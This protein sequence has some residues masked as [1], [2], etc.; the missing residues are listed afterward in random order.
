[1]RDPESRIDWT[2]DLRSRLSTLRLSPAREEEIVEELSQHLD[3]RYQSFARAAE[4]QAR[5]RSR[6]S[7]AH[8]L[9]HHATPSSPTLPRPSQGGPHTGFWRDIGHDLRYAVRMPGSSLAGVAAHHAGVGT[10]Q[11]QSSLVNATQAQRCRSL[12]ANASSTSTEAALP[13]FRIAVYPRR[14]S[15]LDGAAA[16]PTSRQPERQHHRLSTAPSSPAIS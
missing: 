11:Y 10:A 4:N 6:S 16:K 8:T 7:E 12:T 5:G 14:Q 2:L 9:A 1:M 13:E 3:E 15:L